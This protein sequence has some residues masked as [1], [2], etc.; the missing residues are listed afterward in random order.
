MHASCTAVELVLKD[1]PIVH[2]NMVS[3]DRWSLVTGSFTLKYRIFCKNWWSFKTGSLSWESWQWAF[4]IG[5][6][7]SSKNVTQKR[8]WDTVNAEN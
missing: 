5:F 7:V 3:Q 4:K 6:T 2:K 8:T 1:R